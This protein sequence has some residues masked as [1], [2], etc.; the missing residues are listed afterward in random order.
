MGNSKIPNGRLI[1]SILAPALH[2]INS[3]IGTIIIDPDDVHYA[4]IKIWSCGSYISITFFETRI[5][6]QRLTIIDI[7]F[8]IYFVLCVLLLYLNGY[9][10]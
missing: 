1:C 7:Y 4:W 5:E 9:D 8:K 6:K 10:N 2:I 3:A